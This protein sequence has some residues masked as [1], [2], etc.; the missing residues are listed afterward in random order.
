MK[1]KGKACKISRIMAVLFWILSALS[2]VPADAEMP[3]VD[4]KNEHTKVAEGDKIRSE[5]SE[6]PNLTQYKPSDWD[7][8]IVVS[9]RPDTNTDNTV[10]VGKVAYIDCAFAN[11][12]TADIN[13]TFHLELYINGSL[14]ERV[15][16][17]D[18]LQQDYYTYTED[19][20]Y[21][22]SEAGT[23]TLK[24]VCDAD[25][26]V[27]ES[28]ETDNEYR[29]ELTAF[30]PPENDNFADAIMLTGPS[31]QTTGSNIAAT[32]E[33]NEPDHAG[34]TGG[35]SVWWTWTAPETGL[36]Y[37]DTHGSNFDTVLAVY[38]PSG[39]GLTEVSSNNDD[40]SENGN[41]SLVFQ[42]QS[43][44][45]Y[46][47][48]VD[49]WDGSAGDIVMNRRK[50]VGPANDDFADAIMLTGLS[51]QTTGSNISDIEATKE[52]GEPDHAGNFG[53]RSVWWTWTA[54]ETGYFFLTPMAAVLTRSLRFTQDRTLTV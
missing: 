50:A 40:G 17:S 21:I 24:L 37:F 35:N 49:G 8:T 31:G 52:I 47:I 23:Y 53:G 36:F 26:D 41:S 16:Y 9:D 7:D 14:A 48:A 44:V 38:I 28:D 6:Q 13:E 42:A 15:N 1:E 33:T 29:R 43:G 25:N 34:S 27:A 54:P 4:G 39:F 2:A 11:I 18:G 30:V 45:Q 46:H 10:T 19:F 51:G 20:E 32:E 3:S 22:F 12:G 5:R